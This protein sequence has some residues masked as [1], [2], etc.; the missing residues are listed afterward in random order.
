MQSSDYRNDDFNLNSNTNTNSKLWSKGSEESLLGILLTSPEVITRAVGYIQPEDFYVFEN[1]ELYKILIENHNSLLDSNI[2]FNVDDTFSIDFN[3]IYDKAKS[4]NIEKINEDFI[5]KLT[6]RAGFVSQADSLI[7]QISKYSELRKI[8]A[9]ILYTKDKLENYDGSLQKED[10]A[11]YLD[12][13]FYQTKD[14]TNKEFDLLKDASQDYYEKFKE[15]LENNVQISGVPTGFREL[16]RT[17]NGLNQGALII[18]AARPGVGK[19]TF[20]LNIILNVLQKKSFRQSN[21]SDEL[22][23]II[24]FDIDKIDESNI[25][26]PGK[27]IVL[28]SLEMP[29]QQIVEKLYSRKA[30]IPLM[31]LKNPG[32]MSELEKITI[33]KKISDV[34]EH[35]FRNYQ[36]FIDDGTSSKISTLAWKVRTLHRRQKIDLIV[37][38]YLQLLSDD[39]G[40]NRQN[41]I[42]VISRTLKR[43]A[44]EL[45]VPIIALSQLSR[46]V[47][48]RADKRPI[49]SDLRESGSIEQDADIVM[50]LYQQE[51]KNKSENVEQE[52][53]YK[54]Y[55]IELLIK[56]HRAGEQKDLNFFFNKSTGDFVSAEDYT[57][58]SSQKVGD[59]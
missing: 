51:S 22:I 24:N 10:I 57:Q 2:F 50:F 36:L 47:E 16:D 27:R 58:F 28:F 35:E 42:S 52:S 59:R 5:T 31:K 12:N 19:T 20:A 48:E 1:R 44:I 21:S 38:D 37:V 15:R 14:D 30:M 9:G 56:K 18:L 11:N 53:G 13:I 7:M 4:K 54:L 25:N 26:A 43:L 3:L 8:E 40:G 46:K 41:E 39:S 23:D 34:N 55:P 32:I 6:S 45:N 29:T 33:L 49:I 17:I